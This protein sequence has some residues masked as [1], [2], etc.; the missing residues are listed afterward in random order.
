MI[1]TSGSGPDQPDPADRGKPHP[2]GRTG[3][4]PP[5]SGEPHP[6]DLTEPD[7]EGSANPNTVSAR[8]DSAQPGATQ[9]DTAQ[10]D[11]AQPDLARP[12]HDRRTLALVALMLGAVN[13]RPGVTSL[14]PV[15]AEVR[16][17]LGMGAAVAGLLTS[18]PVACFALVGTVAPR[19]ARRF[20]AATVVAAGLSAAVVGLAARVFTT[21]TAGFA[22]FTAL[23]LAGIALVNVLLPAVVKE[24]FPDR[25]GAVTGWYSMSLNA[26][27]TAA[28]AVTVPI[29]DAFGGD[30]RVGLG[31]WAV[32]AAA[33][34]PPWLMLS[35]RRVGRSGVTRTGAAR[36]ASSSDSQSAFPS[37]AVSPSAVSPSAA[38]SP[39]EVEPDVSVPMARNPVAWALAAYF[40]LQATSAYVIIGWLPQ[41]FRDAGLSPT[42][43]GLLFA[44]TSLLGVPL[45]IVLSSVAGRLPNQSGI[46]VGLGAVGVIAYAGLWWAPNGGAWVWAILLGIANCS[47]PLALTMIGLRG[48][49]GSAVVRL[50]A[51][52]QSTGYLIS[53]PGPLLV[54]VLYDHSG[55]WTAPLIFMMLIMVVQL[56]AGH[57]AGRDREVR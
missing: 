16:A 24:R 4:H 21:G 3:P 5:Q 28:A 47:F 13:M 38:V 49:D 45:S 57:L 54:G 31:V 22:A 51:F 17:A 25:V 14:G 12:G 48:R 44:V 34:V 7:P 55:E 53:I 15:L 32:L 29:A 33:S 30:W 10:S 11:T 6:A 56:V 8:P 37:A 2:T 23:A 39:S 19:L 43:A 26:G 1:T 27:A 42:T 50:S 41:V 18:V 46:A 20:S 40:G 35:G 36:P 52:A 9:P